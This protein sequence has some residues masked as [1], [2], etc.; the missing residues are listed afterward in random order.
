MTRTLAA[1]MTRGRLV[2]ERDIGK[3]D[4]NTGGSTEDSPQA[5]VPIRTTEAEERRSGLTAHA[6]LSQLERDIIKGYAFDPIFSDSNYSQTSGYLS[7]ACGLIMTIASLYPI[8]VICGVKLMQLTT[9]THVWGIRGST[10]HWN[11]SNE[12]THGGE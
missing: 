9:S 10:G 1:T 2:R 3:R 5:V 11:S 12:V 8:M 4:D 7:M 6:S